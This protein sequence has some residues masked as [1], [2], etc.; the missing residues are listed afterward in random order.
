M[1]AIA[2][3][4]LL[5]PLCLQAQPVAALPPPESDV[6]PATEWR[7]WRGPRRDGTVAGT[8]W[9]ETL[10]AERLKLAWQVEGLGD[11]YATPLVSETRVFTVGTV[12]KREEVAAAYDRLTGEL[13]WETRWEGAMSVPFFAAKNGSWVRSTPAYDGEALYIGGMRDVLVCLDAATGSERWR[14]DFVE[15]DGAPLPAFG[16]V[17][18]PLVVGEALYLQAGAAV[19]KL[20]KRTGETLW[21]ALDGGQ[22]G[23]MDSSFSSPVL[24][25]LA[26]EEQLIVQSRTHLAALS[27]ATGSALWSQEVQAFRGMNILTPL[28]FND[29]IFT[30]AYGGRAHLYTINR[31]EPAEP[32][33]SSEPTASEPGPLF[34][35]A[36]TWTGRAQGY[37]T[38]PLLIEGHAYLFLRSNRFTC[39]NMATGEDT[40]ISPPTGDEY[41]S[42][43]SQANR[44][45]SLSNTGRLR[46]IP[47]TPGTYAPAAE[48]DLLKTPTWAHLAITSPLPPTPTGADLFIRSQTAL[49][50][51]HWR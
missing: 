17:C 6:A 35:I 41:W 45:L 15:R 12:G 9:P 44:I 24:A 20:D 50:A 26:G 46:L 28:I 23:G 13:L 51:Y 49:H 7:Q 1:L 48:L 47:A 36:E 4:Q 16:L 33:P 42:L 25:R 29:S 2:S 18:S 31:P 3:L 34:T 22:G 19:A 43:V 39:V 37:M 30:T 10:D 21:R 8:P 14:V 11:S 40:Y 32:G 27:P 38:S 5:F